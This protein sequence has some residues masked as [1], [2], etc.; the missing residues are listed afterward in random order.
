MARPS[1]STPSSA[2]AC[3]LR[4]PTRTRRLF[5]LLSLNC[6]LRDCYGQ[7]T[8]RVS[9]NPGA[10]D[11]RPSPICKTSCGLRYTM[12]KLVLVYTKPSSSL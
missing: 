5:S 4:P 8:T 1:S 11:T 3:Y 10:E 12:H 9:P 2:S 6:T 7:D